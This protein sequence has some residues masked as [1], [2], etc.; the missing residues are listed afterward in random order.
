MG[1][2]ALTAQIPVLY[3][4]LLG[5][6]VALGE[7]LGRS[8]GIGLRTPTTL[9]T[10]LPLLWFQDHT[11]GIMNFPV[12][13]VVSDCDP[14]GLIWRNVTKLWNPRLQFLAQWCY[15]LFTGVD[16]VEIIWFGNLGERHRFI[17]RSGTDPP[18]Y[19][20]IRKNGSGHHIQGVGCSLLSGSGAS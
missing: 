8:S 16:S 20:C 1:D 17:F 10:E 18:W 11:K 2:A 12:G 15:C 3:A 4:H 6:W 9:S 7:V 5:R 14:G 19:Y 13:D